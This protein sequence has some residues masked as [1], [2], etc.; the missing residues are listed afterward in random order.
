M[1]RGGRGRVNALRGSH[2]YGGDAHFGAMIE[3]IRVG[4]HNQTDIDAINRTWTRYSEEER[5]RMPQLRALRTSVEAYNTER[6]H[7]LPGPTSI[8]DA[9][10]EV[11]T[12]QQDK[13]VDA[14]ARLGRSALTQLCVK[15]GSPIIATRRLTPSVP[16]GT[17]GV[18]MQVSAKG[19]VCHF[20]GE[21]VVPVRA[22]W[23]VHDTD[24]VVTGRRSQLPF[25]LAWAVTI[26]R[27][28]GSEMDCNCID[29]SLDRTW[30][31]DGLVYAALSR[32]LSSTCLCVRGLTMAHMKTSAVCLQFWLSLLQ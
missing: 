9:V 32:V 7:Q 5:L 20:K 4:A 8:S 30:A 3:R 22:V 23:D 12:P 11:F 19:I 27:A 2:R 24:G 28:Q 14:S 13:K 17:V 16:T 25:I 1:F 10:D 6:L 18:V 15:V 21:R 26:H 31:C 29:F